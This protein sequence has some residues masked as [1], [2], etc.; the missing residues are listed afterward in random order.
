MGIF[1]LQSVLKACKKH[2]END[3]MKLAEALNNYG[4]FQS[5][6]QSKDNLA[7]ETFKKVCLT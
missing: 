7:L 2:Y 1:D 5:V 3:E 4:N 6:C